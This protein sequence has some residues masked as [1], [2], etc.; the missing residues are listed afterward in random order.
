MKNLRGK[1]FKI[2]LMLVLLGSVFISSWKNPVWANPV[3]VPP[4]HQIEIEQQLLDQAH[5]LSADHPMRYLI[6]FHE[7]PDLS[8]AYEMGW[9]MR[10]EFVVSELKEAATHAQ[11]DVRAYLDA[12]KADY[13]SFWITNLRAGFY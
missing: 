8:A 10:G 13:Q 3:A 12:Q 6:Y 2:I 4:E 11:L 9:D 1:F 7:K 5:T